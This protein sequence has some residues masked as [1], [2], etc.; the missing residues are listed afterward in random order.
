[1]FGRPAGEL[2]DNASYYVMMTK[3]DRLTCVL[4]MQAPRDE[5]Y[6]IECTVLIPE[7][8]MMA[9]LVSCEVRCSSLHG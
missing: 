5:V 6:L 9:H 3:D 1:M 7:P 2:R 4:S 8:S